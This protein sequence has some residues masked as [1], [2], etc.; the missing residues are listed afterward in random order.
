M[1]WSDNVDP[2]ADQGVGAE[3]SGP[4]LL[5]VTGT[6]VVRDVW[7]GPGASLV[8]FLASITIVITIIPI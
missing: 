6:G 2:G 1:S 3:G 4:P 8:R 5:P 7:G